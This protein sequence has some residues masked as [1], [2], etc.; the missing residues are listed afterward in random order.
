MV[1]TVAEVDVA[2]PADPGAALVGADQ[3]Q[4]VEIAVCLDERTERE[5]RNDLAP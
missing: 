3:R 2:E 1:E 5:I 4:C